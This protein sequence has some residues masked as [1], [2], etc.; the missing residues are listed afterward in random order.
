[1]GDEKFAACWRAGNLL[2]IARRWIESQ[3]SAARLPRVPDRDDLLRVG[4]SVAFGLLWRRHARNPA[5]G[6]LNPWP[7]DGSFRLG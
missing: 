1:L 3:G 5:L 6:G 2:V 7:K 4:N